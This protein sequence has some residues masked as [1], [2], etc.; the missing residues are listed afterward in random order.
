MKARSGQDR[1]DFDFPQGGAEDS[2]ASD[3]IMDE[4]RE[5][6]HR[7]RKSNQ[8]IRPLLLEPLRPRCNRQGAH[9]KNPGRLGERPATSGGSLKRSIGSRVMAD[10]MKEIFDRGRKQIER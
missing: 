8:R 2:E 9:E 7:L 4:L 10:Q 6:V 3:K 5:L 1:G